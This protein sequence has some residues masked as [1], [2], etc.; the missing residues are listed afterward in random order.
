MTGILRAALD[1]SGVSALEFLPAYVND[2]AQPEVLRAGDQRF[3]R[4]LDYLQWCCESQALETRLQANGDGI[5]IV[6]A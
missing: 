5:R 6:G 2:D 3:S 4:V 1:R